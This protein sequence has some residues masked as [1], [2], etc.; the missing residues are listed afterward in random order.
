MIVGR[1]GEVDIFEGYLADQLADPRALLIDG[2]P[3][4]GK[5]ALLHELLTRG[6]ARGYAVL[7]CRPARSEM[8]LSYAGLVELLDGVPGPVL[9][10]LPPPQARVLRT[11]LRREEPDGTLD[12]LSLGVA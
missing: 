2:E 1:A 6:R 9:D 8:D 5:T 12:R 3:G 11:V 4:I 10:G 7:S